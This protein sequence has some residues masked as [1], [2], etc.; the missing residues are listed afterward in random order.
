MVKDRMIE[1]EHTDS[2]MDGMVIAR[3]ESHGHNF[4]IIIEAEYVSGGKPS[5]WKD[6]ID[7][8]PAD[9]IFADARKGTRSP[10]EEM[11]TAFGTSSSK[12]IAIEIIRRGTVQL[13]T[14]Q[15]RKMQEEKHRQIVATIARE[16]MNPQTKTPHPPARIEAAIAE[17]GIHID[18]MK[19]ASA[20]IKDIV[21]ALRAILPIS[22]DKVRLAIK[23]QG[24]D[25]GK[26]Y[27]DI[28][29]LGTISKGEWGADGSW[30]G[31][32]EIPAG[33]QQDLFDKLNEKTKGN[34]E[35]KILK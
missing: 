2:L 28:K 4:E 29:S 12:D 19:P 3:L 31:V 30:M 14:E 25:Y 34:V 27:G 18:P 24:I 35:S 22:M 21:Q 26:C 10:Q 15:R 6:I 17:A 5:E 9:E 11:D 7:H 8:M 33:L 23:L 16:A 32:V 13:T 20:Q 1:K